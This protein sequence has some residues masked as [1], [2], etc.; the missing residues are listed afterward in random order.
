MP[1]S[2]V[3]APAL[4][5]QAPSDPAWAAVLS[6]ALGV[7][8][9]VT[10]EFLPASL[11]TPM[12]ADLGVTD[13]AAGQAVTATAVI[14]AFAGLFMPIVTRRLDRRVVMWSLMLLLVVSSLLVAIATSLTMVL[15]ERLLLGIGIGGLL[16]D[17]GG[18]DHAPRAVTAA[19]ARLVDR[20]H[21]RLGCDRHGGAG[22][23]L[24]R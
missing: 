11:L 8:G 2:L 24:S 19:A 3:D 4:G 21:R 18:H 1:G 23:R 7:F 10:A 17:D 22:R 6:L 9:L 14:G 20:L 13:G 5:A 16:V 15:A 12:A